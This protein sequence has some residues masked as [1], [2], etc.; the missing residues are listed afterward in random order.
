MTAYILFASNQTTM[1]LQRFIFNIDLCSFRARKRSLKGF[2]PTPKYAMILEL[3]RYKNWQAE[4]N[5]CT[6]Q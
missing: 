2:R 5:L 3:D 1:V 4:K 6:V